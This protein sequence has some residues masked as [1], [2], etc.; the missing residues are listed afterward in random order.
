MH[1]GK[2][3]RV[4]L[5]NTPAIRHAPRRGRA[6]TGPA[7]CR[8]KRK[9]LGEAALSRTKVHPAKHEGTTAPPRNK[10]AL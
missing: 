9:P 4:P 2:H 6:W 7:P 8:R 3:T 5:R 1:G 10:P